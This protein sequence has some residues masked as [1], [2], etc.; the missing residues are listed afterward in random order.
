MR[1]AFVEDSIC[2]RFS[3]IALLRPVFELLCGCKS[4]RQRVLDQLQPAEWGVLVRAELV[5]VYQEE[6]PEAKV[7]DF[8]WLNSGPT[9]LINA[10]WLGDPRTL[11]HEQGAPHS[12]SPAMVRWL[13]PS[14]DQ[15]DN[16]QEVDS[17]FATTAA[18]QDRI[19]QYPW[20]V[21]G[22]NGQMIGLD[23]ELL[24]E[25][26]GTFRQDLANCLSSGSDPA[27]VFVDPSVKIEP[28]V[29]MNAEAGP[30]VVAADVVLQSF[31][32]LEGPCFIGRGSQLFRT[33]L[34]GETSIGP[35]C[36][37]GG[38]IEASIIHGYSNKYHDGFLGHSY[39]CP[40]VNLGALTTN[41]DLKNDYSTVKFCLG[42]EV[43]Q[44]GEK[45]IGCLVGDHAKTTIG[46]LFNTGSNVG[47]M[48]M[49]LPAGKLCPKHI[50][51]FTR[52]WQGV[53]DDQLDFEAA[54]QTAQTAMSRRKC[55]FTPAQRSLLEKVLKKTEQE[56][57]QA[58]A[59]FQKKS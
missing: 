13:D 14:Q 25:S 42:T 8:A 2:N 37:V 29:S 28:Y 33:N 38:E 48:T 51:S 36:R 56:R 39:V 55:E 24:A 58:I 44:T 50:P 45:K 7:N 40:W 27:N 10:R 26:G 35:V 59:R 54:C 12:S 32:R 19:L 30:I 9:L 3:P 4:M 49:V 11:P 47:V 41:S 20:D 46:T 23:A 31:T 16:L 53:L 43:I 21:I 15:F 17:L 52:L 1:I 18:D 34:R 57:S 6:F 5:E 22:F